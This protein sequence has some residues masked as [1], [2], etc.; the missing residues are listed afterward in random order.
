MSSKNLY[1][2]SEQCVFTPD[3]L[4]T[5]AESG[6]IPETLLQMRRYRYGVYRGISPESSPHP[7]RVWIWILPSKSDARYTCGRRR[8]KLHIVR[9][10]AGTKSSLIPLF[11]L[12]PKSLS[13]FR[14]P[15][16]PLYGDYSD[17]VK[18]TVIPAVHETVTG[19]TCLPFYLNVVPAPVSGGVASLVSSQGH[20]P[21]GHS[22]V[23][24]ETSPH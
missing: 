17:S 7:F 15:C 9:F 22:V 18:R 24:E 3:G 20:I 5:A 6:E 10:R 23:V 11:L 2:L 4:K 1:H 12:F 21:A 14:E 16:F 19:G 8:H 13:T